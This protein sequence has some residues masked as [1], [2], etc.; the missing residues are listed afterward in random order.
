MPRTFAP[1]GDKL[2]EHITEAMAL[3]A[4]VD[5]DLALLSQQMNDNGLGG[6][7]KYLQ[8]KT[9]EIRRAQDHLR[10]AEAIRK[11]ISPRRQAALSREAKR[12]R[13]RK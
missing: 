2:S 9:R 5:L 1:T 4:E 11:D 8:D 3:L 13:R 7:A 6:V 12:R 10:A